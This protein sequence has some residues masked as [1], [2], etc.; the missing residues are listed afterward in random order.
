MR[1]QSAPPFTL[2][3]RWQTA[4][5][6]T[7]ESVLIVGEGAAAQVYVSQI[8]GNGGEADGKGEIALLTPDGSLVDADWITGLNAPKVWP[9]LRIA[10]T[11]PI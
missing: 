4:G 9:R 6:R 11:W 8:D 7:P 3:Q 2:A 1:L 5:L 10:C